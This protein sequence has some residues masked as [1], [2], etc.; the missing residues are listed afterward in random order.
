MSGHFVYIHVP[1]CAQHCSYC[2]FFRV[3]DR[4]GGEART[5]A[6]LGLIRKEMRLWTAA[7]D[8]DPSVPIRTLYLGGGTPSLASAGAL[9]RFVREVRAEVSVASDA[10]ITLETQPDTVDAAKLAALATAGVTRFSVGV[11][12]FDP[13]I[14]AQTRRLHSI[15]QSRR[16]LREARS[17]ATLSIDLICAWP[18][19]TLAQWQ[20]DLEEAL[21]FD[22]AH[23]SVYEL[24]FHSGTEMSRR[25]RAGEIREADED[26]RIAMFELTAEVLCGAGFEQYEI[27]N[28]ARPGARSRHNENYWRMGNYVGLGA[29]AHSYVHPHRY[30]NAPEIAGYERAVSAGSLF[31]QLSDPS[32][33][34]IF[35]LENLQMGLRLTEGV[36]L[37]WF[38]GQF[39]LDLQ[40]RRAEQLAELVDRGL[41]SITGNCLRLTHAGRLRLDSIME[42]LI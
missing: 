37:E 24:T 27:S 23:I 15:E 18:G 21:S 11:Q 6:W 2:D 28:F 41:L 35:A 4:D 17:C 13:T 40:T 25:I 14:F 36:D 38:A 3:T 29:G 16:V 8:L 10:E 7:G 32:D 31:R 12:T 22:P 33:P 9:G 39:G 42:F 26:T 5:D 19:Q 20:N 30:E 34:E 1:F